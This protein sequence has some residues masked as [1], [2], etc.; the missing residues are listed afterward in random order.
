MEIVQS[1]ANVKNYKFKE[2]KVYSSTEWLADNKKK[3]RQVFDRFDT[4]YIYAE[5]SFYNKQFEREIWEADIELKCFSLIK[6]KKEVCNLSFKRKI[7]KYDSTVYVREGWGNKKEGSFWKKGTYYWEAWVDGEKLATKYFYIEDSG[8]NGE[9]G[10]LQYLELIGMKL[11]EGP[12]DDYPES[13]RRYFKEF[14]GEETRYVYVELAL[15]NLCIHPLW[16]CELFV[17]FHNEARELKG[18]ITRLIQVRKEEELFYVTAGWGSNV[19]G[20]WWIGDYTVEIVFMD[21]LLAVM[22]FTIGEDFLEGY[23]PITTPFATEP[24]ML[25]GVDHHHPVFEDVMSELDLMIGLQEIKQKVR[26]HSQYLQFIKLRKEKGIEEKD[27]MLLHTVF[28]GNPGTGKTTV[29]RMMGK[30]Y[31]SMGV[32]SK[33][34]VYEADRAELV[35]EFIG[36]TAPKVK[37]VLEKARGG[38]LFIDE[39]YALARTNDDSKDFGREVVELL[40]REMSNG[41]GDLAVILAGYPKEMKYFLDSNPGIKSRIKYYYEFSDYLPQELV[42]IA[43]YAAKEKNIQFTEQAK[44]TIRQIILSA[45]RSRTNSFGNA[46]FVYDLIEKSK[47]QLGIRLMALK[48][49]SDLDLNQLSTVE[50]EDVKKIELEPIKRRPHIPIDEELLQTSLQELDALIGIQKVKKEIYELVQ[51]VR[52][53]MSIGVKVLNQFYLHTIF[54]GNPGTGKSTVARILAKIYKALGILERGHLVETDRQGL[55]AGYVGQSAIK[56]SEKIDQALGGVLFIDEAYSL[57][58]SHTG[59]ADYGGEVIQTLLK[60]MEDQR[61]EFFIFAAGYTEPMEQFLKSNPGLNSRFDKFL[62]FEDYSVEE[63]KLIALK[64]L[65]DKSMTLSA[66][67]DRILEDYI[68]GLLLSKDKHFGNARV[69]RAMIQEILQFSQLRLAEAHSAVENMLDASVVTAQDVL[70]YVKQKEEKHY[71]DKPRI[72]F[73]KK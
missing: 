7:S 69:I 1:Q 57:T 45:Y 55:V 34:H 23:N 62:K 11:Y 4:T 37:E 18:I 68:Q 19:K 61:G 33:G 31:K 60:R 6:A 50:L 21:K 30:L 43:E 56:T 3:Y 51:V 27:P 58:Q 9:L 12:F 17:K 59:Q 10:E 35:G 22:P 70:S 44:E 14:N 54:L 40:I 29:A 48:Q 32:L 49:N 64:M 26:E 65:Q 5:L 38:V 67:A 20:S 46:R 52:Y 73:N 25:P 15:K 42:Q 28:Y 41:P 2:L 13:E 36:Q 66:D 47:M 8:T 24:L 53:S 39:A 71:F 16:Q 63:L 72:G